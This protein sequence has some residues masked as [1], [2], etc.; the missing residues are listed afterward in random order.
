MTKTLQQDLRDNLGDTTIMRLGEIVRYNN[1]E[2]VKHENVAEHSLYV[3]ATI[4]KICNYYNIDTLTRAKALEF[5]TTHDFGEIF[6]GDVAYDTK[7]DNP[8][9]SEIL[10]QAEVKSLQKHMPEF[11]SIYKQFLMEEKLGTV[12]YLITKLAD[13]TSVL[14]FSNREIDLGNST[15][16]MKNINLGAKQRVMD[17]ILRLEQQL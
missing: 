5:G 11:S 17:L 15:E 7:V 4:I 2:K 12:A 14:Q 13:T 16:E 6:L 1:R 9:L 10:E 3:C 8:G